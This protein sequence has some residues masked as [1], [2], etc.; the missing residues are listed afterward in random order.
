MSPTLSPPNFSRAQRASSNATTASATTAAA[1]MAVVSRALDERL[2]RL[3]R[4]E[5]RGAQRAS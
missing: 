4:V 2:G 3:V 5:A 1:L